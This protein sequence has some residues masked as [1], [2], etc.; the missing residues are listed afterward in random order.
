MTIY[1]QI[2]HRQSK[3]TI[4]SLNTEDLEKEYLKEYN[5]SLF[6]S[7]IIKGKLYDHLNNV[8]N[9]AH[10]LL[11]FLMKQ[12]AEQ[13]GVTGKLKATDQMTWVEMMNN[14]KVCAEESVLSELIYY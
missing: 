2:W 1:C 13:Q 14:I 5:K 8:D 10:E 7:L 11:G 12:M 6:S 9:Q 4:Q 3:K